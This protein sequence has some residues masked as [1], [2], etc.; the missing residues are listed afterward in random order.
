VPGPPG[1][2]KVSDINATSIKLTWTPPDV[3]GGSPVT[4]YVIEKKEQF[5]SRFTRVNKMNLKE[6]SPYEFRVCAENKAGI[7]KP[8]ESVGPVTPKPP[9]TV[10]EA[11]GKP[12][13]ME[14][15]ATFMTIRWSEPESDG[16]SKI[17][18]YVVE[19]KDEFST[20]WSK[21]LTD[22][23]TDTSFTITKLSEGSQYQFRV[24]AENKAG[25]GKYSEPSDTKT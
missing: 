10:P 4:G 9:Y 16:G 13:V 21:V 20:R 6:G 3:D 5:S 2:P 19:R 15:D 18:N 17:T 24:A 22:N 8:S 23:M 1:T 12:K 14:V 7:G 25:V 11:P